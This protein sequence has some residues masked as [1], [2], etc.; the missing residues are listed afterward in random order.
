MLDFA[1]ELAH[2]VRHIG[3]RLEEAGFPD[4]AECIR[5]VVLTGT[6]GEHFG[7]LEKGDLLLEMMSGALGPAFRVSRSEIAIASVRELEGFLE[8]LDRLPA[9]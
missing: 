2:V 5:R 7:R 1:S 4:R 8:Y 9:E 3:R 6:V